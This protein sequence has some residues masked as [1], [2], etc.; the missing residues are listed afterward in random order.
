M[1]H[2]RPRSRQTKICKLPIEVLNTTIMQPFDIFEKKAKHFEKIWLTTI[3]EK[4]LTSIKIVQ[5]RHLGG[6][7]EQRG[8][9]TEHLCVWDSGRRAQ[10]E[11]ALFLDFKLVSNWCNVWPQSELPLNECWNVHAAKAGAA[12]KLCCMYTNFGFESHIIQGDREFGR[13]RERAWHRPSPE[14]DA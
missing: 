12:A 7:L 1:S 3:L 6:V 13:L 8:R 2:F 10:E 9:R 11:G 14:I 4:R 5:L